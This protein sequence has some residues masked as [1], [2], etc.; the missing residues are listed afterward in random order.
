MTEA[1]QRAAFTPDIQL[2]NGPDAASAAH[3]GIGLKASAELAKTMGG[4]L[5]IKSRPGHGTCVELVLPR[6]ESNTEDENP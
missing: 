2:S 4:A 5:R 3:L 6:I 1:E